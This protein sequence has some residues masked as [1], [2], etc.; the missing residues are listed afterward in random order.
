MHI[1]PLPPVSY[2]RECFDYDPDTGELTWRDRPDSHFLTAS[3]AKRHRTMRAGR[4]A[5]TKVNVHGY[6]V[7]QFTH[8]GRSKVYPAHR[9]CYAIMN[10]DTDLLVDHINGDRADNRASNLRAATSSQNVA[11]MHN[12][13]RKDGLPGAYFDKSRGRWLAQIRRNYKAIHLGRFETEQEAHAAYLA[14][15]EQPLCNT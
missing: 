13:A 15:K 7:I 11:N 3:K 5:G 2:L 1:N 4:P 6:K 14:A 8:A 12:Y 9:I 10:G